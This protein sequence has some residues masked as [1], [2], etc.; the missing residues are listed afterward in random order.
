[1]SARVVV[2]AM[3]IRSYKMTAD[4]APIVS[5]N[6]YRVY[7][8][9][10]AWMISQSLWQ[11]QLEQEKQQPQQQDASAK[12]ASFVRW[13]IVVFDVVRVCAESWRVLAL[14]LPA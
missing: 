3:G 5:P 9:T 7:I 11:N 6:V 4:S 12:H 1:M 10:V 14:N 2:R 13:T 8:F